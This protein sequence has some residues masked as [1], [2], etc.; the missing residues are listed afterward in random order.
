MLRTVNNLSPSSGAILTDDCSKQTTGRRRVCVECHKPF[1]Q[2]HGAQMACSDECK[3][4]RRNKQVGDW[5]SKHRP[6][7]SNPRNRSEDPEP[8]TAVC[9]EC[10]VEFIQLHGA[11][12]SC[13][14]AC[15]DSRR[16]KQQSN[17]QVVYR[18]KPRIPKPVVKFTPPNLPRSVECVECGESF[19]PWRRGI[20]LCSKGCKKVRDNRKCREWQLHIKQYKT[21]LIC[22]LAK[23]WNKE[24][25]LQSRLKNITPD[26]IYGSGAIKALRESFKKDSTISKL[27]D[28]AHH[29]RELWYLEFPAGIKEGKIKDRDRYASKIFKE[30]PI[31]G[32]AKK[33]LG[34]VKLKHIEL[35]RLL[36]QKKTK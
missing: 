5:L 22:R 24:K 21:R 6:L 20:I 11:Q 17:W 14:R 34:E 12:I 35:K 23:H 10:G 2:Q 26:A 13:S 3:R 1:T 8:R 15:K 19:T 18:R 36:K 16:N 4:R 29:W 31:N 7:R 33:V 30:Y 27:G 28:E 9:V 25:L 32:E